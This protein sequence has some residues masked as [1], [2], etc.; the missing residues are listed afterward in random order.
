MVNLLINE[1]ESSN[2]IFSPFIFHLVITDCIGDYGD[3][4][5][6][7]IEGQVSVLVQKKREKPS[8]EDKVK[9]NDNSVTS[10]IN[11]GKKDFYNDQPSAMN[12]SK[13][14]ANSTA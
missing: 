7:L 8:E 1:M 13:H 9:K 5:Y 3:K 6:I 11:V 2:I 10:S 12:S 4:F 14:Q